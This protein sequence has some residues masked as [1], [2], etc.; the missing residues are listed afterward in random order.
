M[1]TC[2]PIEDMRDTTA[3]AELVETSPT[4]ITVTKN[5]YDQFVVM[6]SD[7]F[8]QIMEIEAKNRLLER[9]LIAERER[10]AGDSCDAREHLTEMRE[11]YGL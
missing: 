2:V 10:A 6:R 4:P 9:I 11:R 7:Q 8:A 5:G 1:A 3:F